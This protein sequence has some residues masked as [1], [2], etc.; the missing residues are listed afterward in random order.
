MATSYKL[1]VFSRNVGTVDIDINKHS[2]YGLV[3]YED[4][5]PVAI[6][7]VEV[8]ASAILGTMN[9]ISFRALSDFKLYVKTKSSLCQYSAKA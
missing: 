6:K 7:T 8:T 5:N 1:V 4:G 9:F 2:G 3:K